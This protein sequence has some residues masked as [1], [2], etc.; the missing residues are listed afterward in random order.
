MLNK[1]SEKI[2]ISSNLTKAL[3]SGIILVGMLVA[4]FLMR[5]KH[6][7]KKV[8]LKE[9]KNSDI[10]LLLDKLDTNFTLEVNEKINGISNVLYY[11]KDDKIELYDGTVVGEDGV[12]VYNGKKFVLYRKEV[13][14]A[15]KIN[16]VKLHKYKGNDSFI[17]DPFYNL[18]LLKKVINH[19]E[20][21]PINIVKVNCRFNL[22][23]YIEEYNTLYNKDIK[24]DY[25][26]K[27][28]MDIIHYT[29]E[30][31]KITID[32]TDINKAI[33]NNNS[34]INYVIAVENI[35]I[36]DFSDI[37]KLYGKTLNK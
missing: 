6:I 19:C 11:Y 33:N 29:N 37:I 27:L 24:I 20:M 22:S 16:E 30:L 12:M 13:N 34:E 2:G 17:N 35:G 36:N 14:N 5:G 18:E 7:T 23:D 9:V 32:Y 4:I 1:L 10:I 26:N 8:V 3:L 25:D 31:G 28:S 15:K 21:T